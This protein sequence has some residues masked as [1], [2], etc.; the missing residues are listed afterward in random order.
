VAAGTL[1]AIFL[2]GLLVVVAVVVAWMERR[3]KASNDS[4][5]K[6]S[7]EGQTYFEQI[8]AEY[9]LLPSPTAPD[10]I[11]VKEAIDPIASK[12]QMERTWSDLFEFE[13]GILK[14]QSDD[15]V[16]R[17]AWVI[18]AEYRALAGDQLYESYEASNPPDPQNGPIDQLR[19]DTE[20]LLSQFH[21]Q[22]AFT[23]VRERA[24]DA[25]LR[26]VIRLLFIILLVAGIFAW[27]GYYKGNTPQ[28]DTNQNMSAL[29]ILPLVIIMGSIGGVVSLQRRVQSV[30]STGD[31]IINIAELST[32]QVSVII[33]PVTGAVFAILLYL[34]FIGHLIG[35]PLFPRICTS[36]GN[37]NQ[38][39]AAE[40]RQIGNQLDEVSNA[41]DDKIENAQQ[42]KVRSTASMAPNHVTTFSEFLSL[43]APISGWDFAKLLIWS[44]IAGFAERFVPDTIDRLVAEGTQGSTKK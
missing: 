38:E 28:Q 16:R 6:L 4:T 8:L 1:I 42:P 36:Q 5:S 26:K 31:P 2:L 18:R 34:I 22:Y 33:T 19:A 39:Q 9:R 23:P 40:S 11:S 27:V 14:L 41:P 10:K 32:S 17:R 35:G 29:P 15:V 3:T 30:P 24:R 25:L 13:K 37:C 12:V 44:F 20:Q 43:T 7:Q 21:W